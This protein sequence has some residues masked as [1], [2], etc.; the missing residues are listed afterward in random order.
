MIRSSYLFNFTSQKSHKGKTI[1]W[2]KR[3]L[4][5]ANESLEIEVS[6]L[7]AQDDDDATE[8]IS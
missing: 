6:F 1:K 2:N 7:G 8:A 5:K 4:G 3:I